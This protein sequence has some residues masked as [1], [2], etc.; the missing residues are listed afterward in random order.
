MK[1][2]NRRSMAGIGSYSVSGCSQTVF[3]ME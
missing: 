1:M 2:L 3:R